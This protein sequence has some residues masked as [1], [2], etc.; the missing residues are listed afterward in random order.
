M[1]NMRAV[2]EKREQNLQQADKQ[3][4]KWRL[5]NRSTWTSGP[6]ENIRT[7]CPRIL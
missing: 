2:R 3:I 6:K 1:Q 7:F 4:D 5:A